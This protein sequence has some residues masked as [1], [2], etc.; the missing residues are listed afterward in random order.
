MRKIQEQHVHQLGQLMSLYQPQLSALQDAGS[1]A[2]V[3]P[4]LC[5]LTLACFW[6]AWCACG[7]TLF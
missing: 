5:L 1:A 4:L 6:R 7:R 3:R 2:E